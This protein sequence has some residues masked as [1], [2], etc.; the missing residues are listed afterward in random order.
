[1]HNI[2]DAHQIPLV[3]QTGSGTPRECTTAPKPKSKEAIA[4]RL[5]LGETR[6]DVERK[7]EAAMT[8]AGDVADTEAFISAVFGS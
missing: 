7:A 8:K 1:M 4:A 6:A 3:P 2:L 5:A